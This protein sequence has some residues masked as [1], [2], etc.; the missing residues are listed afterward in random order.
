METL[1]EKVIKSIV[2]DEFTEEE[3]E[4]IY[5][6]SFYKKKLQESMFFIATM[7][8]VGGFVEDTAYSQVMEEIEDARNA[9]IAKLQQDNSTKTFS[10]DNEQLTN[11]D[12]PKEKKTTS[13]KEPSIEKKQSSNKKNATIKKEA[14]KG[15]TISEATKKKFAENAAKARAALAEQRKAKKENNN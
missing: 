10:S 11:E 1:K 15:R 5:S 7:D 8:V 4:F 12:Q 6:N 9:Y 13:T 2:N 14:K 3:L